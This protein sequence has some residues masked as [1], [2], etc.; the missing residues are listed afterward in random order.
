MI[1]FPVLALKIDD[2]TAVWIAVGTWFGVLTLAAAAVTGFWFVRRHAARADA[3]RKQVSVLQGQLAT[4]Q[5]TC[6]HQL[7]MVREQL[8]DR[9]KATE[10]VLEVLVAHREELRGAATERRRHAAEQRVAQARR[11]FLFCERPSSGAKSGVVTVS[12]YND[13]QEPIREVRLR[14]HSGTGPWLVR[15]TDI[16]EVRL[17][18]ADESFER[19]RAWPGGGEVAEAGAVLEF[20]DVAG[21][22]WQRREHGAPIEVA[23]R[24]A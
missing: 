21:V 11:V 17:L 5:Q 24:D 20:T 18:S 23:E 19:A 2:T 8:A 16:D 15:G 12:V 9:K 6:E 22:R 14:W 3:D 1:R 13:S 7:R 10:G 4:Q